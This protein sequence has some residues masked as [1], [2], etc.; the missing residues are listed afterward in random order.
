MVRVLVIQIVALFAALTAHSQYNTSDPYYN[1][2]SIGSGYGSSYGSNYGGGYGGQTGTLNQPLTLNMIY[3][4]IDS[5]VVVRRAE[6][7]RCV[8]TLAVNGQSAALKVLSDGIGLPPDANEW[9]RMTDFFMGAGLRVLVFLRAPLNTI[10]GKVYKNCYLA[11]VTD[12][13][14]VESLV[15]AY[16]TPNLNNLNG[17]NYNNTG[18][19]Y[20][21]NPASG[22][23]YVSPGSDSSGYQPSSAQPST[24]QPSSTS[25]ANPYDTTVPGASTTQPPASNGTNSTGT[26]SAGTNATGTNSNGTGT[27]ANKTA[28]APQ[29]PPPAGF[30]YPNY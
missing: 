25:P 21:S 7:K 3:Q 20:N 24:N 19:V 12:V 1:S 30:S 9:L 22:S 13:A 15:K 11:P 28:P 29:T 5:M 14:D 4:F 10:A 23:A 18:G 27:S 17:T 8:D 6:I 16:L 26:N 2:G